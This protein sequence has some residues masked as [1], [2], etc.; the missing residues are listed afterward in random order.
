M[1]FDQKSGLL[2]QVGELAPDA[3]GDEEAALSDL[4]SLKKRSSSNS[5]ADV[6]VV[7]GYGGSRKKTVSCRRT[8]GRPSRSR[9]RRPSPSSGAARTSMRLMVVASTPT[10]VGLKFCRASSRREVR[11][12]QEAVQ[13]LDV[14]LGSTSRPLERLL[15]ARPRAASSGGRAPGVSFL[16]SRYASAISRSASLMTSTSGGSFAKEHRRAAGE[17]LDVG[18][19]RRE[20]RHEAV[21]KALLP[22]GEPQ[23][24]FSTSAPSGRTLVDREDA[25]RVGDGGFAAVRASRSASGSVPTRACRWRARSG[26]AARRRARVLLGRLVPGPPGADGQ[27][28][29]PR[30]SWSSGLRGFVSGIRRP[31]QRQSRR[32]RGGDTSSRITRPRASWTGRGRGTAGSRSRPRSTHCRWRAR[33]VAAL[34]PVPIA[35]RVTSA[36]VG[37]TA[38]AVHVESGSARLAVLASRTHGIACLMASGPSCSMRSKRRRASATEKVLPCR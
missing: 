36:E 34:V 8:C 37:P 18:L 23:M 5:L 38:G 33:E 16:M 28:P 26:R 4:S 15:V 3:V 25:A 20:H 1:R 22:A 10:T 35:E 9:R 30:W 6:D 24:V 13:P 31:P 29:R 7:A 17:R 2:H 21:G 27:A 19:V 14:V 11:Q 12:V 32:L